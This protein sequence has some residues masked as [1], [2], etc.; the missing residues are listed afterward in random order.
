M[1]SSFSK[2]LSPS[3]FR[4]NLEDVRS[5]NLAVES[6]GHRDFLLCQFPPLSIENGRLRLPEDA[7][8]RSLGRNAWGVCLSFKMNNL[9]NLTGERFLDS[10]SFLFPAS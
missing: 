1:T 5:G 8:H 3:V 10:S 7:R 4:D 6:Q 9:T 2:A